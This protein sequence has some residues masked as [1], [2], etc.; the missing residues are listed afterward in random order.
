MGDICEPTEKGCLGAENSKENKITHN[1]GHQAALTHLNAKPSSLPLANAS[2]PGALSI[3]DT[4]E[5]P[6]LQ[7]K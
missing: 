3:P 2:L 5:P 7:T 4:L 6:P 1:A